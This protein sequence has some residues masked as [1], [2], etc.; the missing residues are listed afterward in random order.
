[1][2]KCVRVC[3]DVRIQRHGE[4]REKGI[5]CI[6]SACIDPTN[7]PACT[8]TTAYAY[9]YV[10]GQLA[11]TEHTH[12]LKTFALP[13][14]VTQQ[15]FE[16]QHLKILTQLTWMCSR[17]RCKFFRCKHD[18]PFD[19]LFLCEH[20]VQVV[21]RLL[22]SAMAPSP[23]SCPATVVLPAREALLPQT[24]NPCREGSLT[25]HIQVFPHV[26]QQNTGKHRHVHM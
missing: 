25:H 22:P 3:S 8:C 5:S 26:Q 14:V 12:S 18:P 16:E 13:S 1:M 20:L 21:A 15:N 7:T 10:C 19:V 24:P 23:C 9:V 17:Y 2:E 11:S 4:I 6:H